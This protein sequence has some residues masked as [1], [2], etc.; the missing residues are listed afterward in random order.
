MATVKSFVK[1]NRENLLIN[2]KSSF[3]GMIDGLSYINNGFVKA[4]KENREGHAFT[5]N[6]LQ[7]HTL[8][9][10]GAWFVGSSRDYIT[11]FQDGNLIGFEI[12]NSCGHF[13]LA[14]SK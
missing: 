6:D 3:D 11:P 12:Y 14:V 9:I 5:S 4:E 7:K 8:G 1:K 2:L 10:R 13:Y